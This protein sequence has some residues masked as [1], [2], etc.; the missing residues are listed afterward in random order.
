MRVANQIPIKAPLLSIAMMMLSTDLAHADYLNVGARL[1]CTDDAAM[2]QISSA[3]NDEAMVFPDISGALGGMFDTANLQR[4]MECSLGPQTAPNGVRVKLGEVQKHA[5]GAC[6]AAQRNFLSL[7]VDG[8]KVISRKIVFDACVMGAIDRNLAAI[9]YQNDALL[10]CVYPDHQDNI[11]P[12]SDAKLTCIDAS[13]IYTAARDT[14]IDTVE[15]PP[16][17]SRRRE[18]HVVLLASNTPEL[19]T[20]LSAEIARNTYHFGFNG[21]RPADILPAKPMPENPSIL[22]IDINNDGHDDLIWMG[23]RRYRANNFI[24]MIRD[25]GDRV[26]PQP[27]LPTQTELEQTFDQETS[28]FATNETVFQTQEG[29]DPISVELDP[30]NWHGQAYILAQAYADRASPKWAV[31]QLQPDHSITEI[32]L[33]DRVQ[34]NY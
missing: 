18:G 8:H 31:Y 7:W 32:C 22:E 30:F 13:E 6:G 14:P 34:I 33:L 19:C 25:G 10:Y 23:P 26:T 21:E 28:V 17:G 4:E 20:L 11:G 9:V 12:I 16:D 5:Y 27:P 15:Y 24:G 29:A 3:W 2:V 1:L